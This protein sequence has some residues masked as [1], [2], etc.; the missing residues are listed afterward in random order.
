MPGGEK[1]QYPFPYKNGS[2]LGGDEGDLEVDNLIVNEDAIIVGDLTVGGTITGDFVGDFTGPYY[3]ATDDDNQWRTTSSSGTTSFVAENQVNPTYNFKNEAGIVANSVLSAGRVVL[4]DSSGNYVF[5]DTN[6]SMGRIRTSADA[7]GLDIETSANKLLKMAAGTISLNTINTDLTYKENVVVASDSVTFNE[8]TKILGST[9]EFEFAGLG[10]SV[11][12]E[13]GF[14]VAATLDASIEAVGIATLSAQKSVSISAHIPF[15]GPINPFGTISIMSDNATSIEAT[16]LDLTLANGIKSVGELSI[17]T[18]LGSDLDIESGSALNLTANEDSN[19]VLNANQVTS[20]API[21][22]T[23]TTN[24]T[25]TDSGALVVVG[26]VGIY[27]DVWIGGT[28]NTVSLTVSGETNLD[29]LIVNSLTNSSSASTGSAIFKG[30]IGVGNNLWVGGFFYALN[31]A[32]VT[33]KTLTNKAAI[34]STDNSTDITDGALTVA[35]GASIVKDLYVG[36]NIDAAN[37]I[38]T[39]SLAVFATTASTSPDTGAVVIVGGV[40]IGGDVHMA[41][42]LF[43]ENASMNGDTST[44]TL[45]VTSST[46]AVD[47]FSGAATIGGGL[48][49]ADDVWIGGGLNVYGTIHALSTVNIDGVL[50]AND[51]KCFTIEAIPGPGGGSSTIQGDVVYIGGGNT[52]TVQIDSKVVT[53]LWGQSIDVSS[54]NHLNLYSSG[55]DIAIQTISPYIGHVNIG[56]ETSTATVSSKCSGINTIYGG[57]GVVI[58]CAGGDISITQPTVGAISMENTLGDINIA[59]PAGVISFEVGVGGFDCTSGAAE[60]AFTTGIGAFLVTTGIGGV[61]INTGAGGIELGCGAGGIAMSTELGAILIESTEGLITIGSAGGI[62]IGALGVTSIGGVGILNLGGAGEINVLSALFTAETG[63][64]TWTTPLFTIIG[65]LAVAA[66][67]TAAA[68]IGI[69]TSTTINNAGVLTSLTIDATTIT[70]AGAITTLSL[71]STTI[72]NTGTATT[73]TLDSITINN[74]GTIS[75]ADLITGTLEVTTS[76]TTPQLIATGESNFE[77]T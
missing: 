51:I 17:N 24:S 5:M 14:D 25:T 47:P 29:T 30:G 19:I 56:G 54:R 26:G 40:G 20:V 21:R 43:A 12:C 6:A 11:A 62:V 1:L 10:F 77:L 28:L 32:T 38:G 52:G 44:R 50:N 27:E 13:T 74:T 31:D 53:Q 18:G 36:N 46:N 67:E 73:S 42:S 64:V 66:F 65:D 70:N 33:G 60:I 23:N 7:F 55:G 45:R 3:T 76:I 9:T 35:G 34:T 37:A 63:D 69:L 4:N 75:T 15:V 41:R 49:V 2:G 22:I 48:G 8:T 71:D 59:C 58:D 72:T 39:N 61:A 16:E 57:A 68:T